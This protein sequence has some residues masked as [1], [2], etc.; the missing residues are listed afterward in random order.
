MVSVDVKQHGTEL[1]PSCVKVEVAVPNNP[2][3]LGG[4]KATWNSNNS[5]EF[6]PSC[7][8]VEVAI[9]GH[10]IVLMVSVDVKR[11]G[12]RTIAQ[13]SGRAV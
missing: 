13:S 5:T 1:K 6:R 12:T 10:L 9:L 4:R 11:H 2:Y 7:V 3:G 8:K